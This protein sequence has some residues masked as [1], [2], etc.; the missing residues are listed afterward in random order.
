LVS[1]AKISGIPK[2]IIYWG[3]EKQWLA[4][5][6]ERYGDVDIPSTLENRLA[7]VQMALIYVN[8]EGVNGHPDPLR[9]AAQLRETFTR[10]VMND[11]ETFAH[12]CAR[13][14]F[15]LP[16]CPLQCACRG[17]GTRRGRVMR[18]AALINLR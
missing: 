1:A 2:R 16:H 11:E 14:M 15:S 6:V 5:S 7:A 4:R 9:T 12:P 3:A 17:I 13:C 10:M 18:I 8:P